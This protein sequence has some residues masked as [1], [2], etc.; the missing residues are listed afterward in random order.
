[1]TEADIIAEQARL[2]PINVN[3]WLA[4][5]AAIGALWQRQENFAI[6][7][8][9][10]ILMNG[11]WRWQIVADLRRMRKRSVERQKIE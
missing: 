2:Q 10:L 3:L 1:M 6:W 8:G 5:V 9:I 11:A 4:I 7:S